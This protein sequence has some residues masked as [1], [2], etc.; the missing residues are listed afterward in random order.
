MEDLLIKDQSI[1]GH[2]VGVSQE[3][4]DEFTSEIQ[5]LKPRKRKNWKRHL[6][7]S[8]GQTTRCKFANGKIMN[9]SLIHKTWVEVIPLK[10]DMQLI[11]LTPLGGLI[12][13]GMSPQDAFDLDQYL[14]GVIE[15]TPNIA[16]MSSN[17]S[18][19]FAA[20]AIDANPNR[21]HPP[22]IIFEYS[23]RAQGVGAGRWRWGFSRRTFAFQP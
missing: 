6:D 3:L 2:S 20:R 8:N 5:A 10:S 23:L 7:E 21:A 13:A 1:K 16:Y 9:W 15:I 17:K 22:R 19:N 14:N 4:Y 12:E 11:P 18:K